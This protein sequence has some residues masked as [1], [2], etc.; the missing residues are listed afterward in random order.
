MPWTSIV[1][2]KVKLV[3]LYEWKHFLAALAISTGLVQGTR[4]MV[5]DGTLPLTR[6]SKLLM[7]LRADFPL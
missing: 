4:N 2:L 3:F 5:H 1:M 7:A 6:E